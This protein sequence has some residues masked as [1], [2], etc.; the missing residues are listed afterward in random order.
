MD[1]PE[2]AVASTLQSAAGAD[3][4]SGRR[5]LMLALATLGFALNFWAWALLSPLGP[6]FKDAL[7]LTA[8]QQSLVVAVP[9]VV[10]ALGRIPVGALTDR[11]GGRVMFPVVSA[12]TIVPVLYLG[13]SGNTSLGGL[14]IGGFLL[15]VGGTA[16]AVGIPF[17][18]AWFPPQRRGFALGIF[19]AGMGGTAISA[20]T[21]VNLVKAHGTSAPFLLTATVLAAYA[22][23][24]AALLRDA[25]GRTVPLAG[26]TSRL[27]S[28]VRL[29]VTWQAAAL[30]AVA[31]G[32]YVAFSVYLPTYLKNG[33]GLAQA[34]ASNRMAGFVLV[35][36]AMRPLGGYLSDRFGP[37]RVLAWSLGFVAL[38]ACVQAGTPAL[39]PLG[40]AT[41]LVMGAAL[42]AGSGAVFALV[43]KLAPADRV[44]SVTGVVGAAG[45]LGGFV[46]PLVM[47]SLY[48]AYS[49]YSWGLLL[50][51][52]VA[53]AA[54]AFTESKVR[55]GSRE[56][57]TD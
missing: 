13:L 14:L 54:F 57:R 33:Y 2:S 55:G 30:Y 25:P 10:G 42:G 47:G 21:T 37:T 9:V 44:G 27:R 34:D 7:H 52:V 45:G 26:F 20:L 46:P 18:G 6:R 32:G 50:L 15:G 39:M 49:S 12:A 1:T 22:V 31:F 51:A 3:A 28:T 43:A 8:F 53:T 29:S 35:A 38:G 19:G 48:G 24:A 23:L 41:F 17:V 36:V 56:P 16:F 11:F 4:S 40:T 5:T